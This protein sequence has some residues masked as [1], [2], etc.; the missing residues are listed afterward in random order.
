MMGR[1]KHPHAH[2][3]QDRP[4]TTEYG[5]GLF[6]GHCKTVQSAMVA[7]FKRLVIDHYTVANITFNGKDLVRLSRTKSRITVI[8]R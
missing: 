3:A 5:G 8:V 7:A 4:F 2:A 1:P 6:P